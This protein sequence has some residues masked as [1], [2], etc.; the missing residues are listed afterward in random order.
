MNIKK[1]P[2]ESQQQSIYGSVAMKH[3]HTF[4]VWIHPSEWLP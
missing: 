2:P 3:I 1:I 4:G